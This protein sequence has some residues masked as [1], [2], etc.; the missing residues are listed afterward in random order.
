MSDYKEQI[1][2]IQELTY[3]A[4]QLS[5]QVAVLL[6]EPERRPDALAKALEETV[7][8]MEKAAVE[9]RGLY[10]ETPLPPVTERGKPALK[11]QMSAGWMESNQYGWLHIQLNTLLPH[12][13]YASPEWITDTIS[14]ILDQYEQRFGK[15]PLLDEALVVIEEECDIDSRQVFDQDNK[16]W[17]AIPNAL[18]GRVFLDDD[19]F[20]LS[21]CLLSRRSSRQRCHIY[22]LPKKSAGDFF[23]MRENDYPAFR[24]I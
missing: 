10:E 22:I 18:K 3:G 20:H 5:G 4:Y 12:C 9:L 19:Q 17:K 11:P 16:G 23:S 1:K 8:H 14:R 21:L 24:D 7:A 13:R 2:R 15:F 6:A